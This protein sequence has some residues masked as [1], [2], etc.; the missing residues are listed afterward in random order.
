MQHMFS[1]CVGIAGLSPNGITGSDSAAF[2]TF[3]DIAIERAVFE[4][5]VY[6]DSSWKLPCLLYYRRVDMD[7]RVPIETYVNPITKQAIPLHAT[8]S[9]CHGVA[10]HDVVG[11]VGRWWQWVER[12]NEWGRLPLVYVLLKMEIELVA[13]G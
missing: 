2:Y 5:V 9:Q 1:A 10:W 12:W 6:F 13:V 7:S 11:V 3:N 4:E 8:S